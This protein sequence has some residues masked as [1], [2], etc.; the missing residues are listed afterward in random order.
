MYKINDVFVIAGEDYADQPN[1]RRE[2]C[3][4]NPCQNGGICVANRE[5]L[6]ASCNCP[7]EYTGVLCEKTGNNT[8]LE[9]YI[10]RVHIKN[11]TLHKGRLYLL[12]K[13]F[14]VLHHLVNNFSLYHF[15]LIKQQRYRETADFLGMLFHPKF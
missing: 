11:A 6:S 10:K 14:R 4:I 8:P 1:E 9:C 2:P 3:D 12:H 7:R 15:R 13:F 5:R